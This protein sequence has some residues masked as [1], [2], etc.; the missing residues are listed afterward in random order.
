VYTLLKSIVND[1]NQVKRT[2]ADAIK[3]QTACIDSA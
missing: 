3:P 2:V 1:N